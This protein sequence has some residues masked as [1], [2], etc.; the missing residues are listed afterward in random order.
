MALAGLL[1]QID[2]LP[3]EGFSARLNLRVVIPVLLAQMGRDKQKFT[4]VTA[5]D[6]VSRCIGLGRT[7]LAPWY[8][9]LAGALL[10]DLAD[11][12]G[13]LVRDLAKANTDLMLLV[14]AT[15]RA[16][17]DAEEFAPPL[18]PP[19]EGAAEGSGGGGGGGGGAAA[20]PPPA[21]PG[22]RGS[23]VQGLLCAVRANLCAPDHLTRSAALRWLSMLLL[24][25]PDAVVA[26][27]DS[28]LSTLL[29]NLTD[30]ADPE[31]LKLNLEVLA[32]LATTDP[33]WA[34]LRK[35]ILVGLVALFGEQRGLLEAKAAFIVRRLCLLLDPRV[36]YLGLAEILHAE[37]NKEFTALL[38]E[39]LNLI[40]LTSAELSDFRDSLRGCAA[41]GGEGAAVFTALFRTWVVNPIASV[42]LCLLAH[43]HSLASRLVVRVHDMQVTVGLLMQL[44]KLVQLL[45]SPVFLDVRLGL[46]SPRSGECQALLSTLYGLLMILPQGTAYATLKDRLT[47]VGNLHV[48]QGLLGGAG[49]GVGG[50]AGAGAEP[51]PSPIDVDAAEAIFAESQAHFRSALSLEIKARSVV[52]APA[53]ADTPGGS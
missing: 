15:T 49:A 48:A 13:E 43:A 30:T 9:L 39:L 24:Q 51:L 34:L 14:R 11:T 47:A 6:W 26:E 28:L 36:V 7:R 31:V 44:D 16:E 21:P 3:P 35:R 40:L 50:G 5:V 25:L 33:T 20:A 42:S 10:G 38:V 52:G 19:G 53:A 23:A 27:T 2:R 22:K 1:S 45:E 12:D 29:S 4:R 8:P 37:G 46:L 41:R 17:L 18:L 32:R